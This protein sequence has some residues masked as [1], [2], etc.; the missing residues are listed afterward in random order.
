MSGSTGATRV[1]A[2]VF[3]AV[4][5]VI[6]VVPC[7]PQRANAF[8]SAWMPAPPPE[9]EPAIERQTGTCGAG[10]SIIAGD[11]SPRIGRRLVP[12][13]A[14]PLPTTRSQNDAHA[15]DRQLQQYV[16]VVT[17]RDRDVERVGPFQATFDPRSTNPY[18]NYAVPDD[19]AAPTLD[20]V[21]ALAEAF[22]RRDRLPRLEFLPAV[23]PAVEAALVA[24]GFRVEGRLAVMTCAAGDA[25]DVGTPD[26]IA[27]AA[28]VTDDD[29]RGMR[30]AQ[31][32]AFGV[33]EPE[34]DD[35]ELARRRASMAAGSIA[36]L[37]RDLTTGAVVGGGI[38]TVPAAGVTE[39]AGIGVLA[40]HRRRGIAAAITAG[41][42]RGAFAAALKTVWL[43]PGDAGAHRVYARAGFA[44]RTTMLHISM[45]AR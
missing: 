43:T 22:R 35:G 11:A 44:D 31:H 33:E 45:P 3:W 40:S 39:V 4:S 41:L 1:T 10:W 20:A 24:G 5:A 34:V 2:T 37:A 16:R 18:L 21:A 6:A 9:S 25:A 28:P 29:L 38:A 23:A 32:A 26:G 27:I 19:D 36:L 15:L 8:R 17:A 14:R 7:T 13:P 12:S 42:A 30:I